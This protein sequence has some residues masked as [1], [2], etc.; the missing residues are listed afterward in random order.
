M[1][2]VERSQK[3]LPAAVEE[4]L[5]YFNDSSTFD[6]QALLGLVTER[7]CHVLESEL[8]TLCQQIEAGHETGAAYNGDRVMVI[9]YTSIATLVTMLQDAGECRLRSEDTRTVD[10]ISE[11]AD[12]EN[13]ASYLRLY[14]SVHL[15]DPD[16]GDHLRRHLTPKYDWLSEDD[17]GHAYI[18]SFITPK[19]QDENGPDARDDLVYWRA[20]GQ[21]GEGC[22]LSLYCRRNLLR[23]V[24]YDP[25]ESR[26]TA[27]ILMPVLDSVIPLTQIGHEL[28]QRV[29]RQLADTVWKS[30]ARLRYLYKS[31]AYEYENECRFVV[32]ETEI[33]DKARVHLEYQDRPGVPGRI[34][35]Y[36]EDPAL[37]VTGQLLTSNSRITL[38]PCVPHRDNVRYCID[39]LKQQAGLGPTVTFSEISYRRF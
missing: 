24:V 38:G 8:D 34:R 12:R 2:K 33:P 11:E 35:H 27:S 15:N 3:R 36:Y 39:K 18:S 10:Q 32:P 19:D 29:R 4:I 5:A 37:R 31:K 28:R 20:Y 21:D 25:D 13:Q 17:L 23:K 7:I 26:R 22:S 14:D 9:H 30:L 1:G 16:E 6:S